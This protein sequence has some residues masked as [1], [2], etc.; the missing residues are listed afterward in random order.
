M[1]K[2][3]WGYNQEGEWQLFQASPQ[4]AT[5]EATGYFAVSKAFDTREE[6][7]EEDPN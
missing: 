7:E 4:D 5:P 6:A 2:F 3:Y 1:E